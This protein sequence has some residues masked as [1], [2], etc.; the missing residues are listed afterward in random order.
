MDEVQVKVT[1]A[2]TVIEVGAAANVTA[3]TIPVPLS[4][5][6]C[7]PAPLPAVTVS[8]AAADPTEAGLNT[9]LT[10]HFALTAIEVP[11]VLVCENGWEP[12]L[13]SLMLVIGRAAV[14]VFVTVTIFGT[15][16]MFVN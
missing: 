4:A 7:I 1:E 14:L 10:A 16:A 5:T 13:E 6:V 3:G 15:L 9:I 8:V 11:Q 2:P 12:V